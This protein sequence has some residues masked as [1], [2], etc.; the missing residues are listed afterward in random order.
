MYVPFKDEFIPGVGLPS[1]HLLKNV[2]GYDGELIESRR[3]TVGQLLYGD[4]A[5]RT[6]ALAKLLELNRPLAVVL[7]EEPHRELIDWLGSET[8]AALLYRDADLSL[9]LIQPQEVAAGYGMRP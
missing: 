3:A 4:R 7:E 2:K 1:D 8:P 6:S 9:W 5:A